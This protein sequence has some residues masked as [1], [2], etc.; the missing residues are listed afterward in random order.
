M[1]FVNNFYLQNCSLLFKAARILRK[2]IFTVWKYFISVIVFCD[3]DAQ[4]LLNKTL[5]TLTCSITLWT[6]SRNLKSF[7]FEFVSQTRKLLSS[8][9]WGNLFLC[10]WN[11][12]IMQPCN[13]LY[14]LICNSVSTK[15]IFMYSTNNIQGVFYFLFF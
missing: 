2:N 6:N 3:Q 8:F 1:H 5:A 7:W 10:A 4:H 13:L 15:D 9:F 14:C 12:W 11:K